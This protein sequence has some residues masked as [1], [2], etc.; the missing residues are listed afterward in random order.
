[1]K[2]RIF[3]AINLP[4]G[5]KR[6]LA[7]YQNKWTQLDPKHIRW[8]TKDNLHITLFF[9]GY[10]NDD[11]MYEIINTVKEVGKRHKS[12]FIGLEKIILGP[13][14]K[15]PRMFWVEGE[16]SQ[17]L[18]DLQRDLENS[19]AGRN[20]AQREI[21]AYKPHITL[22]RF[23]PQILK[24]LSK[25]INDEFKAQISVETIEIMQ[26]DLR[27]TGAEYSI[28]ESIELGI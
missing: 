2:R 15:T 14:D 26:S 1:M 21:R 5:I 11:E 10:V 23:K 8:V 24:S 18:A 20:L 7:E 22:A 25:E 9:I 4:G 16:K 28:L 13:P 6:R 27:R 12:F 19:I 17:E 3:I